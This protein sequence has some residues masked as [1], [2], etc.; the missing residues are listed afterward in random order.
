[1]FDILRKNWSKLGYRYD[2][3][4]LEQDV[5]QLNA[6]WAANVDEKTMKKCEF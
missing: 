4:C 5:E 1:M 2:L 3:E 6:I